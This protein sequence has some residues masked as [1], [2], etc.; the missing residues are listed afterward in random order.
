M[1]KKRNIIAIIVA[2]NPNI[3]DLYKNIL[4]INEQ[5]DKILIV[6]NGSK[7][8]LDP[9]YNVEILDNNQN[10]GIAAALNI[11]IKYSIMNKFEYALLMDQD[12]RLEYN[13]VKFLITE[14]QNKDIAMAVPSIIYQGKTKKYT[15]SK[16]RNVDFAITSGSCIRLSDVDSIGL[17]DEKLFIDGVDFDYCFKIKIAGYKITQ[18]NKAIL[19]QHL[20]NLKEHKIL[21]FKFHPTN[22][23]Y[24]RQYY[25]VR[26]RLYL[27]IK[28]L[29]IN[30]LFL[31]KSILR[32]TYNIFLILIFEQ[33]K[34]RKLT[35]SLKGLYDFLLNRMG[36][37][38]V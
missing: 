30:P 5:V 2:Y 1:V 34:V 22:H 3:N 8:R 21:F 15:C 32:I 25:I 23:N 29:K 35:Y 14:L 36:N 24:I 37:L 16:D 20:G 13:A 6:N 17:M 12:S 7:L 31:C 4:A 9:N 33:D 26:N 19:Y 28:Y 18:L 10:L 38:K 27:G 11:G